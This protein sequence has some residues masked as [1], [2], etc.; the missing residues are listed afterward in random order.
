MKR[1]ILLAGIVAGMFLVS[2]AS[3]QPRR[4]NCPGGCYGT[5]SPEC[6]MQMD[7]SLTGQPTGPEFRMERRQ[8]RR[9]MRHEMRRERMHEMRQELMEEGTKETVRGRVVSV[10]PLGPQGRGTKLMV[11]SESRVIPVHVGP[12]MPL[13]DLSK[14]IEP[15]DR[16]EV[17][18][19]RVEHFGEPV[20]RAGRIQVEGRDDVI[21]RR[22]PEPFRRGGPPP[23]GKAY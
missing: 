23:R 5:P 2:M 9:E 6:R 12:G 18:G 17:S 15:N 16:V 7:E 14:P 11:E 21:Q 1:A 13:G 20:L 10:E 4:G 8:M 22:P 19:L 3:A